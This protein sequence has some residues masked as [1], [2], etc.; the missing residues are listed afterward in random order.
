[1][2]LL[3]GRP[4]RLAARPGQPFGPPPAVWRLSG[5]RNAARAPRGGVRVPRPARGRG[6]TRGLMYLL[7][8]DTLTY[9]YEGHLRLLQRLREAGDA[10][11]GIA[12]VTKI[13]VLQGRFDFLLKAADAPQFRRAQELLSR[14][15]EFLAPLLILPIN[16]VAAG[17]FVRLRATKGLK[18]FGRADLL[19]LQRYKRIGERRCRESLAARLRC[20]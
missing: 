14:T 16:E 5:R 9:W 6:M 17:Y 20:W 12:I 10:Q 4:G 3:E 1:M 7:D 2:A 18:K 15:E 19:I 11:I 8:T 13:E